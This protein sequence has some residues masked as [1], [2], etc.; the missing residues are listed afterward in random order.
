VG[1]KEPIGTVFHTLDLEVTSTLQ[2]SFHKG[3]GDHCTVLVDI[4]TRSAIG[5][6]ELRVV[7]P[8]AQ[9]LSLTNKIAQSK[10]IWLLEAQ[11]MVHK[12]THRLGERE[13][14]IQGYPCP[15][16]DI[17]KM[18]I[19]DKQMVEMQSTVRRIAD[20]SLP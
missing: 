16:D 11:M 10:Y 20:G 1:G 6:Q 18:E 3:V 2:L 5:K 8:H 14:I 12:M 7:H 9:G 4:S 17:K 19:L 13:W 15:P